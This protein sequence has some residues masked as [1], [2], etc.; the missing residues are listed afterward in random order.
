MAKSQRTQG[1]RPAN[2]EA[3]CDAIRTEFKATA[4]D[5]RGDSHMVIRADADPRYLR[6]PHDDV[7]SN[8]SNPPERQRDR[9]A[10]RFFG[11]RPSAHGYVWLGPHG[12]AAG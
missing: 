6:R 7:L 12:G 2:W 5:R 1:R 8:H 9:G 11:L 10:K 3:V 4:K